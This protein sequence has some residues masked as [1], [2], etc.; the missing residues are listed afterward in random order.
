[1]LHLTDMFANLP[2]IL[3]HLFALRPN[4]F[5]IMPYLSVIVAILLEWYGDMLIRG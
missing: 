1:M 3:P 4:V 5:V 2:I